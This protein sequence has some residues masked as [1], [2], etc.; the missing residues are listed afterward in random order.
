MGTLILQRIAELEAGN[1]AIRTLLSEVLAH[2]KAQEG[3]DYN[4]TRE[5]FGL[6]AAAATLQRTH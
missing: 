5:E 1:A 3:T 6:V 4:L 2:L